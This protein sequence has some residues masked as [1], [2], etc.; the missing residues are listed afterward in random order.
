M[1]PVL[2]RLGQVSIYSY[3]VAL[4]LAFVACT[5]FVRWYL[6]REGVEPVNAVDLVLAAAIGGLVG[7]RALYVVSSLPEFAAHPLWAFELWRGGMVFYGGAAGGGLAVLGWSVWRKLPLGVVA[8][9]GAM[10]LALG[11][12]IG[13]IGCFLNGCCAGV[14]TDSFIGVTFPGTASK[15]LPTQLIDSASNLAMF[16][17]LLLLASRRSVRPGVAWWAYLTLYGVS[18]FTIEF[19]RIN[20][21]MFLGLSQGQVISVAVFCAGVGGLAVMAVRGGLGRRRDAGVTSSAR[22]GEGGVA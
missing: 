19:W 3:G 11:S 7:A 9:A 8:D 12:A 6:P 20:P 15:V 13:R 14:A 16:A 10:A 5:L 1:L 22:P 4:A 2:F 18:R 17:L 21:A